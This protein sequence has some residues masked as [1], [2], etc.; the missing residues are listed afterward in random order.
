[1]VAESELCFIMSN[2]ESCIRRF[3]L[4]L[5]IFI[6]IVTGHNTFKRNRYVMIKARTYLFIYNGGRNNRAE[7][8]V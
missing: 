3:F 7:K 8:I 1:M 2:Y 4:Y 6:L 5:H